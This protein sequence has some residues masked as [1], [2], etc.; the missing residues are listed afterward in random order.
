MTEDKRKVLAVV[1]A[2]AACLLLMC[3]EKDGSLS[4]DFE[5]EPPQDLIE[6]VTPAPAKIE[7]N[8]EGTV[9]TRVVDR[10]YSPVE[11]RTV[12]FTASEGTVD[13]EATTGSDGIATADFTA[14]S[15]GGYMEITARTSG[16]VSKSA[17]V[18]ADVPISIT[19]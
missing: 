1:V 14:P 6:Y 7:P 2:L 11:G 18:Q 12:E 8:G 10:D 9:S 17:F 4:P 5:T 15:Q 3:S 16:A 13:A 19:E